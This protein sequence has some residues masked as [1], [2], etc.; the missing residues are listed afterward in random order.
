MLGTILRYNTFFKRPT[1]LYDMKNVNRNNHQLVNVKIKNM[2]HI[3][4]IGMYNLGRE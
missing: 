1:I 3:F 2:T 4:Y